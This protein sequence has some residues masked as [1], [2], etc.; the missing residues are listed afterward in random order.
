MKRSC[1]YI[2]I[3]VAAPLHLLSFTPTLQTGAR[4]QGV[5]ALFSAVRFLPRIGVRASISFRTSPSITFPAWRLLC[6][7]GSSPAWRCGRAF[8][9]MLLPAP[10]LFCPARKAHIAQEGPGGAGTHMYTQRYFSR[11]PLVHFAWKGCFSLR[12]LLLVF[13]ATSQRLP[14]SCYKGRRRHIPSGSFGFAAAARP[15]PTGGSR[16]CPFLI[17]LQGSLWHGEAVAQYAGARPWES[18]EVPQLRPGL[19]N[20][21]KWCAANRPIWIIHSHT[22]TDLRIMATNPCSPL[23]IFSV[24]LLLRQAPSSHRRWSHS[25]LMA[26]VRFGSLQLAFESEARGLPKMPGGLRPP[27]TAASTHAANSKRF[28]WFNQLNT[29]LFHSPALCEQPPPA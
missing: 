2:P 20:D 27:I 6:W 19:I 28:G 12:A 26:R 24:F 5:G 7:I 18:C 9:L 22:A 14:I 1:K 8:V 21:L 15:K 10:P 11:P 4:R 16:E 13:V 25:Q 29:G 17:F 3:G 23:C